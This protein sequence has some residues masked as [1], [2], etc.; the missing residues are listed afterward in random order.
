M[1]ASDDPGSQQLPP[2]MDVPDAR[3]GEP[4]AQDAGSGS[5]RGRGQHRP[6]D[7]SDRRWQAGGPAD[8]PDDDRQLPG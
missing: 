2:D 7:D 3:N 6:S 1:S 8:E 5:A 4:G